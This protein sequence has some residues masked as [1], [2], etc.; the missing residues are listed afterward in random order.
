M[1][2]QSPNLKEEIIKSSEWLSPYEK[3]E[4]AKVLLGKDDRVDNPK[5]LELDLDEST[6]AKE[7]NNKES[8]VL[9]NTY[10]EKYHREKKIATLLNQ[11]YY[12]SDD[13]YFWTPWKWKHQFYDEW[14]T[15]IA[16]KGW[17]SKIFTFDGKK[18]TETG[19]TYQEINDIWDFY[20]W[21]QIATTGEWDMKKKVEWSETYTILNKQGNVIRKPRWHPFFYEKQN[22]YRDTY[23]KEE[24]KMSA[25]YN[26]KMEKMADN[27]PNEYNL[28]KIKGD[29]LLFTRWDSGKNFYFLINTWES[30]DG[31]YISKDEV[32]NEEI[33]KEYQ[34]EIDDESQRGRLKQEE[35][36]KMPLDFDIEFE[37]SGYVKNIVDISWNLIF[38]ANDGYNYRFSSPSDIYMSNYKLHKQSINKWIFILNGI[39]S[40][41]LY[42][43]GIFINAKN[44][45]VL[46][47]DEHP[48]G[49][50]INGQVIEHV[51]SNYE[52]ELYNIDW[53]KLWNSREH[54]SNEHDFQVIDKENGK[55]QLVE[56][57][58]WTVKP[59]E[60]NE[61]LRTYDEWDKKVVI[62]ENDGK[63]YAIE[64]QK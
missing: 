22:L 58:T 32:K 49:I 46:R 2:T 11:A 26:E 51:I 41:H 48:N 40:N 24:K 47:F 50:T 25:Y 14:D 21:V 44:N 17:N 18:L 6:V 63:E 57:K 42:K 28:L 9:N 12:Q 16:N 36:E 31:K 61:R 27:I 56:N 55:H 52:V 13:W 38:T 62:V 64:I 59:Q 34:Q 19:E 1:I 10:L 20:M 33:Y 37:K 29:T 43:R 45:V 5:Q 15:I 60:Y 4:I 7:K 3:I 35:R 23:T 30:W 53:K 39:D 54:I 8:E